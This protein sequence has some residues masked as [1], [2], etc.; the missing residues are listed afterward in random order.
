M[1]PAQGSALGAQSQGCASVSCVLDHAFYVL[2]QAGILVYVQA[3][4]LGIV[5]L[6]FVVFIWKTVTD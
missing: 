3:A 6:L 5:S 4:V 1:L 2:N